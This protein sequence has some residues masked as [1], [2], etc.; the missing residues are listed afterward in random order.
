MP[1]P[2]SVQSKLVKAFRGDGATPTEAFTAI[3]CLTDNS[4]DIT[5]NTLQAACKDS[6]AW[7]EAAPDTKSASV[8]L[9]LLLKYDAAVGAAEL[10][11]DLNT[12]ALTNWQITTNVTGDPRW[13]F[14]AYVTT[15]GE[16]LA[17]GEFA[18]VSATLTISGQ[19]T[20][21]TVP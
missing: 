5:V 12:D 6:G 17:T 19:V 11:S 9:E 8:Q 18:T 7:D 13:E 3:A 4:I 16:A 14:A 10:W 15:Y 1:T 20:R 21:G 2:G